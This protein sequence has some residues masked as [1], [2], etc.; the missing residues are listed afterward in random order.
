M[1][2]P[3]LNLKKL[4]EEKHPFDIELYA[5]VKN[6]WYE[7]KQNL[8][9][10]KLKRFLDIN[11]YF[12]YCPIIQLNV[13]LNLL[14]KEIQAHN[15]SVSDALVK[16]IQNPS[17][18]SSITGGRQNARDYK[19]IFSQAAKYQNPVQLIFSYLFHSDEI[20]NRI[21]AAPVASLKA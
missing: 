10:M 9:R 14:K 19:W 12:L 3:I 1:V 13:F 21:E 5:W 17:G 4:L 16:V 18:L 8:C 2:P 7:W 11:L 15:Q 20:I 6:R